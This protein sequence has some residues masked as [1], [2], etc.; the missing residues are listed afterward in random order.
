M[1]RRQLLGVAGAMLALGPQAMAQAQAKTGGLPVLLPPRLK[2]GDTVGLIEPASA[3]WEPF[4]IQLIEEALSKLGLKSKRAHNILDRDGYFAGDDKA[5]ADGVNQMFADPDVNAIM[6]VRG[7]WGTARILPYLDFDLIGQ[8]PK[9]LIGYSDITALH[10]AI[11]AK[12]G[13]LTF[14]GPV[15]ISAWGKQSL[16]TFK[17]LLFDAA[18]PDYANPVAT[19]D[20][21]VQRKWRTQTITPGKARGR[22]LGGNL[23]VMTA[24][25]GTPY[26]PSFDGAILFFEDI[27][28]AVY[29][30]DRMLT[31][32]GQADILG[33][34]AGVIVGNCTDCSQG[35][36]IGG[37]TLTEVLDHHL[38]PLGVPA[39][40]GA[41]IGHLT[42][43]FTVPEGGL[44]ELDA[45][46]GTFRLLEPAVR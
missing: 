35:S 32:L 43:Q 36:S 38:K 39:F 22:L 23:T 6:S 9:A 31:Q 12:T 15:G 4:A 42:D 21:L 3:T 17:P 8:N 27:D 20:R 16:E 5:R 24:L 37:F 1:N 2:A 19:E 25:V 14:H 29:R 7:G 28:E 11:H 33:R 46:T 18:T 30:V 34:V 26:L 10:L 41:F 40:T 13:M 45:D 44:V